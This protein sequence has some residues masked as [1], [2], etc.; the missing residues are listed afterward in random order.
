MIYNI[1]TKKDSRK[2]N[3]VG[4]LEKERALAK[5]IAEIQETEFGVCRSFKYIG[6]KR[7]RTKICRNV[8]RNVEFHERDQN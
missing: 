4:F 5:K 1:K 2:A 6:G 7:G 3:F 8:D